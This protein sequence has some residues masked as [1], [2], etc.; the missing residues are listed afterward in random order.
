MSEHSPL[1]PASTAEVRCERRSRKM[2][3]FGQAAGRIAHDFSNPFTIISGDS[4]MLLEALP[5][6][7]RRHR[8]AQG[9]PLASARM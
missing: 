6:D 1:T 2:Q 5:G 8:L 3:A 7:D 9:N 4:D